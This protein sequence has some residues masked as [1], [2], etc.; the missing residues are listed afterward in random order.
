M[1]GTL[2]TVADVIQWWTS[3]GQEVPPEN[4]PE[5]A[6]MMLTFQQWHQPR[7]VLVQYKGGG[8]DG[9]FWEYNYAYFDA[10]GEFHCIA[11][12]GYKG[13]ETEEDLK[14]AWD[15]RPK[16]FSPIDL[17][18]EN[19]QTFQV[20]EATHHVLGLAKWFWQEQSIDLPITCTE[21]GAVTPGAKMFGDNPHGCGGVAMTFND[22]LCPNCA[23]NE[24]DD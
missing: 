23:E 22:L 19:W 2:P 16:D 10:D 13:C 21:C 5:W 17:N 9:C 18:E 11:A 7:N 20:E 8:Y 4:T 15:K 6:D 1:T 12:T 3:H 24:D 14:E